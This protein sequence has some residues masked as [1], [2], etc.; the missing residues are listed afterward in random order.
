MHMKIEGKKLAYIL[1]VHKHLVKEIKMKFE[2]DG[3]HIISVDPSHT[4]M[5]TTILNS[6]ACQE[7][8]ISTGEL[9]IGIDLQKLRNFLKLG[10]PSD[11]FTFD[12]DTE[13]FKLVVKLGNIVRTMGLLDTAGWP[14]PKPITLSMKNKVIVDTKTFYNSFKGVMPEKKRRY[15]VDATYLTISENAVILENQ[16]DDENK[17]EKKSVIERDFL[18]DAIAP[19]SITNIYDTEMLSKQIA[20]YKKF[21][22]QIVIGL[23]EKNQPLCIIG[24]S[25]DVELEYWL[26]PRVH[27][28]DEISRQHIIEDKEIIPEPELKEVLKEPELP[29]KLPLEEPVLVEKPRVTAKKQRSKPPIEP[30]V[31]VQKAKSMKEC[32]KDIGWLASPKNDF[33][34]VGEIVAVTK[35]GYLI[36]FRGSKRHKDPVEMDR[37]L[38]EVYRRE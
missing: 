11:I 24:K 17:G 28:D 35:T 10:K 12:Y 22:G 37:D 9:E 38:V 23:V 3:V 34:L 36:L 20:E 21:L 4:N 32:R 29:E 2:K 8:D 18:Q 31:A 27:G 1:D 6:G 25:E 13:S 14:D 16:D 33:Y 26:A 15:S 19:V 7:Y 5:I 30:I